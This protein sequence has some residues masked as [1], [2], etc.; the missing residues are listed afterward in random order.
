MNQ[1]EI[2]R[3]AL[4][5][6]LACGFMDH[7]FADNLLETPASPDLRRFVAQTDIIFEVG[8]VIE[9]LIPGLRA[10]IELDE[11]SHRPWLLLRA[12]LHRSR[13]PSR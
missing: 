10:L 5:Y 2:A 7:A 3:N 8:A 9:I 12:L 11:A 13:S 6:G 4:E 1:E